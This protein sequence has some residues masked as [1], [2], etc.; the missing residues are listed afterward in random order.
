MRLLGKWWNLGLK[1]GEGGDAG[2]IMRISS[3]AAESG[4]QADAASGEE[5]E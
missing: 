3:G 2:A 1:L 4:A 5:Q